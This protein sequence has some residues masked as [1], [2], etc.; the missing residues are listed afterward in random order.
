MC[1]FANIYKVN[2][3]PFRVSTEA[4]LWQW[5]QLPSL[6]SYLQVFFSCP[7]PVCCQYLLTMQLAGPEGNYREQAHAEHS[8]TTDGDKSV[9]TWVV[10]N[11]TFGW[12]LNWFGERWLS[13]SFVSNSL[14]GLLYAA[15][16]GLPCLLTKTQLHWEHLGKTK[17]QNV[18]TFSGNK[19]RYTI[20]SK[21]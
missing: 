7:F 9:H 1:F 20:E 21:F 13:Q 14:L 2:H 5:S 19:N 4:N 12:F 17:T 16:F 8:N 18:K 6:S 10:I 11:I 15:P 3:E